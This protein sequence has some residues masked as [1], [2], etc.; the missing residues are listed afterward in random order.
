M[1]LRFILA[2]FILVL[3][4][5][6]SAA[7]DDAYIT[8]LISKLD[9]YFIWSAE[10]KFEGGDKSIVISAVGKSDLITSVK[11]LNSEKSSTGKPIKVRVVEPDMIPSNS[12]VLVLGVSDTTLIK[13]VT[14]LLKES[15]TLIVTNGVGY[16]SYGSTLNFVDD[17]SDLS[18]SLIELNVEAAKAQDL[19]VRPSLL[20][21]AKKLK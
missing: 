3:I 4:L 11:A 19:T 9:A 21:I 18:K 12:H 5:G 1:L 7:A 2:I 15:G 17:S 20:K 14:G 6:G 10:K 16:G 8:K 13:K